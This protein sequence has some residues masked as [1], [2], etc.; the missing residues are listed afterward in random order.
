MDANYK[1]DRSRRHEQTVRASDRLRDV[2]VNRQRDQEAESDR[3]SQ[4]RQTGEQRAD[5]PVR[6]LPSPGDGDRKEGQSKRQIKIHEAGVE[7]E[8]V[9]DDQDRRRNGPWNAAR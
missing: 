2:D 1:E 3:V 4:K 9:G 7:S 5:N 6:A 8:A